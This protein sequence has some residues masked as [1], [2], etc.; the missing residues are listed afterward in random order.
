[1]KITLTKGSNGI[2]SYV[3]LNIDNPEPDDFDF[4]KRVIELVDEY[5]EIQIKNA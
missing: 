3:H 4:I 5:N 2:H 1:M